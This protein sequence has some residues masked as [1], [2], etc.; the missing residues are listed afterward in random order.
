MSLIEI[1]RPLLRLTREAGGSGPCRD[2][3]LRFIAE[4][5]S[6]VYTFSAGTF[7]T[8]DL[9]DENGLP[10]QIVSYNQVG[11][12]IQVVVDSD[13]P[14]LLNGTPQGDIVNW[15]PI[16]VNLEDSLGNPVAPLASGLVANTLTIEVPT[17][18]TP[19]GVAFKIP[20][21]TQT[22]SFATGP[23]PQDEGWRFINGWWDYVA[24]TTPE[25]TAELQYSLGANFWYRLQQTLRVGAV[26]SNVR[27]VDVDGGQ[28]WDIAGN[29]NYVAIDKLTGLM[30]IR[31]ADIA[32]LNQNWQNMI[33]TVSALSIIV[34]GV[35][36]DDWYMPSLMEMALLF[37]GARTSVTWNDPVSGN[38]IMNGSSANWATGN[39]WTSTTREDL[40]TSASTARADLTFSMFGALSAAKTISLPCVPIRKCRNLITAS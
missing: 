40:V 14:I 31:Y 38:P 6:A 23:T 10:L 16:D 39:Y 32:P 13:T 4:P 19:A 18:V 27:F 21:C 3:N 26:T 1:N 9:I 11:A 17:G 20:P 34:D 37:G 5:P 36:Y 28:T 24:P 15:T 30:F 12:N 8:V 29:K 7:I 22:T 33:N 2:T 25:K 35:L